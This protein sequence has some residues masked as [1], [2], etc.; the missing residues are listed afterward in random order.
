V[1]EEWNQL[2]VHAP[3]IK[4]RR[5]MLGEQAEKGGQAGALQ[6]AIRFSKT[7]S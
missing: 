2:F 1:L 3:Q 6:L 4:D 7:R 5:W